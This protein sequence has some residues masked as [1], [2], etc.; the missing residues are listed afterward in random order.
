ML[1]CDDDQP[2]GPYL[3]ISIYTTVG[4]VMCPDVDFNFAYGADGWLWH[5]VLG[6]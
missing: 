6:L 2:L 5:A 4:G 3:S 1:A